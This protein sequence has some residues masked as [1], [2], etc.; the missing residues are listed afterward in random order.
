[1]RNGIALLS[2]RNP[3][4]D[5]PKGNPQGGGVTQEATQGNPQNCRKTEENA[6]RVIEGYS[7]NSIN[8]SKLSHVG[9]CQNKGN[10]GNLSNPNG[11][12]NSAGPDRDLLGDPLEAFLEDPPQ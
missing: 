7:E 3:D 9:S 1:M 12:E 8:D 11:E 2:D 5:D 4:P 6:V 10:H